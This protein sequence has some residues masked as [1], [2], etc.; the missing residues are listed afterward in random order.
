MPTSTLT[1][2]GQITLPKEI[3]DRLGLRIGDRIRFRETADGTVVLEPETG[4]L[5]ALFGALTPPDGRHLGVEEMNE[6][7]RRGATRPG[8]GR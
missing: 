8:R 3:R 2:K 1:S 7:I 5:M 4:S 6:A